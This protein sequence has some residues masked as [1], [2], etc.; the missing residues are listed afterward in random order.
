MAAS[1]SDG[2]SASLETSLELDGAW[3]DETLEVVA[4]VQRAD[5]GNVVGVAGKRLGK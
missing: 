3:A 2:T 1:C 4:F 5:Q